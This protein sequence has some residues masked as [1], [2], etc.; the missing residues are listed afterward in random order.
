[1][2]CAF[3]QTQ[4]VIIGN[5]F[6]KTNNLHFFY[7]VRI[8]TELHKNTNIHKQG[9]KTMGNFSIEA[10]ANGC[11]EVMAVTQN[12]EIAAKQLLEAY[13]GFLQSQAGGK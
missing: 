13:C 8:I 6:V 2:R 11:K 9:A 3:L 7:R 12:N 5:L 10:F 4:F 1:M